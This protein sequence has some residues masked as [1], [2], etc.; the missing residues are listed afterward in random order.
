MRITCTLSRYEPDATR[1]IHDEAC[2]LIYGYIIHGIGLLQERAIIQEQML[3]SHHSTGDV[4]DPRCHCPSD[5][6]WVLQ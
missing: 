4:M 3:R 1:S 2:F 5:K 6:L